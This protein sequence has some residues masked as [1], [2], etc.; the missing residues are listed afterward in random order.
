VMR[1][2]LLLR[3]HGDSGSTNYRWDRRWRFRLFLG[4]HR[5]ETRRQKLVGG[6]PLGELAH[7]HEGV[8]DHLDRS[9][10]EAAVIEQHRD[11]CIIGTA[12]DGEA[13][14]EHLAGDRDIDVLMCLDEGD[15]REI[16]LEEAI[17]G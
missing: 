5:Q 17:D 14:A 2:L 8:L 9:R 13:R 3:W 6:W 4:L 7:L 15:G 12:L 10:I 11:L 16:G 1:S